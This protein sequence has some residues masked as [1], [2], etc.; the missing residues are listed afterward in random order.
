MKKQSFKQLLF[1]LAASMLL[2]PSLVA[3]TYGAQSAGDNE[4]QISGGF[5][6]TQG[7]DV[8]TATVDIAYGYHLTN[9]WEIGVAQTFNYNFI[10]DA[11]DTWTASTIPF[12]NYH[13]RGLSLNDNFQPFLGAF[14]GLIY[15]DDD[16][17]GTVGPAAGFKVFLNEKTF[18]VTRYRYEW[19]FD[20]IELGDVTDTSHGNHV[21]TIGLGF[22]W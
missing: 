15:N 3:N 8:G 10:D 18:L 13:L 22:L 19:F 16:V 7:A 17:T 21:V 11:D 6:H 4:I 20:E 5:F 12:V 2:I 9:T 1:V 14:L